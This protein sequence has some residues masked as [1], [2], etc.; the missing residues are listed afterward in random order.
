VRHVSS[1]LCG[2][3]FACG[4]WPWCWGEGGRRCRCI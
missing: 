4:Q 3:M 2:A 1:L